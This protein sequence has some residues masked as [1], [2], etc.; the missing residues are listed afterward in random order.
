[1]TAS[2]SIDAARLNLLLG[3]LRLPVCNRS[4]SLQLIGPS[5]TSGPPSPNGPTRK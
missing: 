5:S 3:E 2:D 1:M 4:G